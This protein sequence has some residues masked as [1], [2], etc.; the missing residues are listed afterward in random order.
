MSDKKQTAIQKLIN[1]CVFLIKENPLTHQEQFR[2]AAEIIKLKSEEELLEL[3][4]QQIDDAFSNGYT[5]GENKALGIPEK[6]RKQY[7]D[8]NQYYSQTYNQ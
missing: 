3:E 2:L 4:R 8:G 7:E 1:Y 6:S 5:S